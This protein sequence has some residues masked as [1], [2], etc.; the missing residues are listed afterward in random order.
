VDSTTDQVEEASAPSRPV[1]TWALMFL[2]AVVIVL[3]LDWTGSGALRPLWLFSVPVL[4]GIVGAVL[5]LKQAPVVGS[6]VGPMGLSAD[7]GSRRRHHAH[8]RT[9]A[10]ARASPTICQVGAPPVVRAH[11]TS[12]TKFARISFNC[13]SCRWWLVRWRY[14]APGGV[15]RRG[16]LPRRRG[17]EGCHE[18]GN[19]VGR[20]RR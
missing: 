7:P 9:I 10:A 19:L 6:D 4:L 12:S 20:C 14:P 15:G 11:P 13:G 3:L 2:A 1:T 18:T 8:Q 16:W 17:V 5:A